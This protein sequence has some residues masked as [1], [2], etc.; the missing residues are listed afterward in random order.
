MFKHPKATALILFIGCCTIIYSNQK[1]N[2]DNMIENEKIVKICLNK[3]YSTSEIAIW[4]FLTDDI[5]NYSIGAIKLLKSIKKN[6]LLSILNLLLFVIVI[7]ANDL[8]S[9]ILNS[10]NQSFLLMTLIFQNSI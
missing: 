8:I 6:Y 4:T 5:G 2:L 9:I 10:I 7:F 3:Q 1:T